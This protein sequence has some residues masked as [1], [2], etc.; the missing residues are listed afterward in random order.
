MSGADDSVDGRQERIGRNEALFRTV[1]ERLE[2]LNDAFS[3]VAENGFAIVCECGNGSCIEQLVI[4]TADYAR[5]RS[6]AT[7]FVL[8]AGHEDATAEA[9]VEEDQAG[10]VVVRKHPG[11]PADVAAETAPDS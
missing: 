1:N 4:P 9:V 8:V 3:V 11:G 2:G 10:Y 5:I 7:L 6:D